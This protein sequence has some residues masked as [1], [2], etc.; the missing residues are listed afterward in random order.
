MS[1]MISVASG[2]QYSVNISYD[3]NSEEKL[4]NYIPTKAAMQLMEDILQSTQPTSTDR[5]RVLIGAYG[6]GKSHIV[7][8]ILSLLMKKDLHLF[9]KLLPA[10]KKNPTLNQ[11]IENYYAS[12]NKL[13]PI[14]ITGSNT[15]LTQAF[16]LALQRTL[17]ENDL[18]DIM[19]AT[20]YQ[21]AINVIERWKVEY[22]NTL[23]QFKS[24]IQEP[25]PEFIEKLN[26][27]D[28]KTYEMF[29]RVYPELTAGSTF[30]PFLGFDVVQLYEEVVHALKARG[31]TGVYIVYDEFSKYLEA[32]IVEASVSDT[33]MLQDFAEK[34]NRSGTAQMHLM[35]ISHKE[36]ANYIDKLPKQ[37]LDGWRGVSERFTHIHLNNNFTQTYE[38]IESVI[39]KKDSLW[40]PFV[41]KYHR[42]FEAITKRYAEHPIFADVAGE[43]IKY[44][45][46]G[47]YPLHPVSTFILPRLSE[48][49]AQN[50]RTLFTFLSA[51][52]IATLPAFL[53]RYQDDCF[54]VITPDLIY[55]YFEPL[56]KKEVY[57]GPL[58]DTYVL[59]AIILDRL[60]DNTLEAKLVKALS[61]IYMLEQFEKLKPTKD[62]LIGIYSMS[63]KVPEIERAL[64]NLIDEEYVIYLK[65]SN[66]YLRLKQSSGV[67]V[68]AKIKDA[69]ASI[70]DNVGVKNILNSINFD[71]AVYPYRYND[72][73]ELTR[74]FTFEFIEAEEVT[75]N[76]DWKIKSEK[77]TADGVVYAVIP[78]SR[79]SIAT[80]QETLLQTSKACRNCVFILPRDF[81]PMDYVVREYKAVEKLKEMAQGD[82]VLFDEYEVIYE[83]LQEILREYI[84]VYTRPE[85]HRATYIYRGKA[86]II[87][88]KT[89][90]TELLS[91][92]CFELY[93][94]TPV[95]VNEAINKNAITSVA[96]ASRN[97]I[98]AGLLRSELEP[99]LGLSGTGQEVS[100]MRSTLMRT[101]ILSDE[102]E[103]P[104]LN[105]HPEDDLVEEMLQVIEQ[106]VQDASGDQPLPFEELYQRLTSPENQIGLRRGVIPIYMAVVFHG[107]RQELLIKNRYGQVQLNNDTILQIE[108][109]PEEFTLQTLH[110]N[111]AR[112]SYLDGVANAFQDYIVEE[113][114]HSSNYGYVATAIRRWYVSL[115]KYAKEASCTPDGKKIDRKYRN[116]IKE[117]KQNNGSYSML[118]ERFPAV[119]GQDT[120]ENAEVLNGILEAKHF[121]DS[122]LSCLRCVLVNALKALFNTGHDEKTLNRISLGSTVR[123]WCDTLNPQAFEQLFPN[124]AEK[125]LS[126]M[127]NAGA[128]EADLVSRLGKLATDLR[129][130]D[131]DADTQKSALTQITKWK[132]TAEQFHERQE[133][134]SAA[135]VS[136][137]QLIYADDDG[138]I[139]TKRFDRVE[140]TP[141]GKLLR[142]MIDDALSGMGQAISEQEKR[143]IL[144]DT[145]KNLC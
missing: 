22:P 56:F 14:L 125:M 38:I 5:A 144:M 123:D 75:A 129:M 135:Q 98:V 102:L 126:L 79:E 69:M 140:T 85:K 43:A 9:E 109:N 76:V 35:L 41:Q 49:V 80:L 37:K 103:N 116:F 60:D 137:Y 30:N 112:Q 11:Q 6:K 19:P 46:E 81:T 34:C 23:E 70:S 104:H 84:A 115:P 51:N 58:H 50:E 40:K 61:L 142:N 101:G 20:N 28:I 91:D 13:L 67:D 122:L 45:V 86:Q 26:A 88:R 92:I 48:R 136:N 121:Y 73:K 134:N 119:F 63:Y 32:N 78:N 110:W 99:N 55:D 66:G 12:E 93:P 105:L 107:H 89:V 33:K 141:K 94:K 133:Q 1:E 64:T 71:N 95:I 36:I 31:Y 24:R 44:V 39:L 114:R 100:I 21:A 65:R 7:L 53:E 87:P 3:L 130:E 77:I 131:W 113:D 106:F 52:G 29:E 62:E 16:L 59:T 42:S 145:L 18:I 57:A 90:L 139:V 27:Y 10:I 108:A 54:S 82:S 132:E 124:G 96:Q 8:A 111:Q 117:V 97:K 74:Y 83:D 25:L 138:N 17:S 120:V 2:F 128:D 68:Q 118:F 4:R 143:Q 72:E 47:C 127:K 15:S